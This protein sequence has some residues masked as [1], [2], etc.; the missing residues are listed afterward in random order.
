MELIFGLLDL[1]LVGEIF[2]VETAR[3]SI[4]FIIAERLHASMVK[5]ELG[6]LR[7]SIDHVADVMGKRLD[8]LEVRIERLE[9]E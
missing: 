9:G 7:G 5:K 1:E 2:S 3:L 8:S 6:L 4:A